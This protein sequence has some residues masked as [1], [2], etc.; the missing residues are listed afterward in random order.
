MRAH[1]PK[2]LLKRAGL[3]A[4]GMACGFALGFA[5]GA[6]ADS[7]PGRRGSLPAL[8]AAFG[9]AALCTPLLVLLHEA[10]HLAC[11]LLTGYRFVS[12]RVQSR[13]WYRRGGK[14][15]RGRYLIPGT[16]GQCLMAPPQTE[17]RFP[18]VLY[19]LGGGLFNIVPGAA[20]LACTSPYG[21]FFP[22]FLWC[23]GLLGALLGVVNL[24]PLPGMATDGRNLLTAL[25]SRAARLAFWRSLAV[26]W[27]AT[28]GVRLR[29][30]P[31]QWFAP[32]PAGETGALGAGCAVLAAARL[33]DEGRTGEALAAYDAAL[34]TPGLV[35]VQKCEAVCDRTLL[36]LAL[37]DAAAAAALD[38]PDVRRYRKA[39]AKLPARLALAAAEAA[40]R[41]E[42]DAA[43]AACKAFDA[44]A[45]RYPAAGEVPLYRELMEKALAAYA[46]PVT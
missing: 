11:G 16:G 30:M 2:R 14:L 21:G 41:G 1:S 12:Y 10:G 9:C 4:L 29:D 8:L 13:V 25:R 34:R 15:C 33:A 3:I 37:G 40:S 17:E 44:A 19:N 23:F 27:Q 39:T 45:A 43:D 22:A 36:A 26:N 35:P 6:F 5:L 20:L 28:E 24:L 46:A 38:A 18:F 42:R 32:L 31:A 7:A